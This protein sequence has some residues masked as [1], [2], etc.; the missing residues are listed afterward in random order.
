MRS[1]AWLAAPVLLAHA[2]VTKNILFFQWVQNLGTR[3]YALLTSSDAQV[4][5]YTPSGPS[6]TV[7]GSDSLV[8]TTNGADI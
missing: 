4:A 5:T 2:D 3:R 1:K 7:A 8:S 6:V